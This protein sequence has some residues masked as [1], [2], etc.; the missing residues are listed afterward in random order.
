MQIVIR[1]GE[2]TKTFELEK[3]DELQIK[4]LELFLEHQK[5][6][7]FESLLNCCKAN[8]QGSSFDRY[9]EIN[10]VLTKIETFRFDKEFSS[11]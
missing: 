7:L 11:V 4:N 8:R 1:H 10:D 9:H 5:D 3:M 6:A 2:E